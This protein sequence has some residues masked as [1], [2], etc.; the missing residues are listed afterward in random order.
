M[1][2]Y[3]GMPWKNR[4]EF[5]QQNPEARRRAK[6]DE[7]WKAEMVRENRANGRYVKSPSDP[8]RQRL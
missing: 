2:L 6:R 8:G 3:S 1:S 7:A 5:Y 4:T